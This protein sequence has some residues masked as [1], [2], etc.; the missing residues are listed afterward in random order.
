M[1]DKKEILIE[2]NKKLS[3]SKRVS[4]CPEN[5]RQISSFYQG[6]NKRNNYFT[7]RSNIFIQ[8]FNLLAN[9]FAKGDGWDTLSM[10]L[11]PV[12]I[13]EQAA[14]AAIKN[15]D[16]CNRLGRERENTQMEIQP[17]GV[18]SYLMQDIPAIS[19]KK[20]AVMNFHPIAKISQ[21]GLNKSYQQQFIPIMINNINNSSRVD[22]VQYFIS[23]EKTTSR[24]MA[25]KHME[26]TDESSAINKLK[27]VKS[28]EGQWHE[29]QNPKLMQT[30]V[31]GA[32]ETVDTSGV[33]SDMFN[34]YSKLVPATLPMTTEKVIG[35]I[36]DEKLNNVKKTLEAVDTSGFDSEK[37]HDYSKLALAASFMTPEKVMDKI[38]ELIKK[39]NN[40]VRKELA[41]EVENIKIQ[42]SS[43]K[44]EVQNLNKSI[45]GIKRN[46][47]KETLKSIVKREQN[48]LERRGYY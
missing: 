6:L 36:N 26:K 9:R 16:Q 35:R 21:D 27:D 19:E 2:I 48:E 45:P 20:P 24:I 17:V 40:N 31:K 13:K 29:N 4:W 5:A 39:T 38:D 8:W 30:D 23:N 41:Q 42:T 47:I 3:A 12:V 22:M 43:A 28:V 14:N 15:D 33:D 1:K 46:V 37:L 34:D 44:S 32:L 18:F 11:E 25:E 10:F 7:I